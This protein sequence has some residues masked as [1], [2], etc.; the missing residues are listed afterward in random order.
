MEDDFDYMVSPLVF[1]V[2]VKLDAGSDFTIDAVFGSPEANGVK[3][4][5]MSVGTLFPSAKER[6]D[7]TKG[8]VIVVK[9]S[10][11][12]SSCPTESSLDI[13]LAYKT[14]DGE[15]KKEKIVVPIRSPEPD[16][17][18][19]N[20]VRKA[21]LL[22]H[23]VNLIRNYIGRVMI[24][25]ETGIP[26]PP[27]TGSLPKNAVSHEECEKHYQP[28]FTK[29]L[30]YFE[31]EMEVLEDETLNKELKVLEEL[32][33]KNKVEQTPTVKVE[34]DPI[35]QLCDMGFDRE[36]VTTAFQKTND[37]Q[38]VMASLLGA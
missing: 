8:G 29:F 31:K 2:S 26:N 30:R 38:A 28:L 11:K 16:Y 18:Q 25:E 6:E 33:Q 3:G 13:A 15:R 7:E 12:S 24:T 17:F 36:R 1:D 5:V 9:L 22:T 23:Y 34:V 37:I 32:T 10:P 21:V 14:R 19:D 4:T 27:L 20:G 35:Q